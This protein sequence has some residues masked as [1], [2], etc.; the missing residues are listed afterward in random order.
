MSEYDLHFQITEKEIET[1]LK[2]SG[3]TDEGIALLKRE[4]NLE[5]CYEKL[6]ELEK[7]YE[8]INK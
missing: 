3:L 6:K 1:E 4:G 8:R 2:K 5:K 7:K